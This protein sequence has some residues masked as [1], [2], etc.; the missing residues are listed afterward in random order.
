MKLENDNQYLDKKVWRCLQK[1]PKHDVKR[2]IRVNS[3]YE[4][5]NVLLFILYFLTFE[6]FSLNKKINK[7]LI[8]VK[9]L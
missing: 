2:N 3:V 1:S 9:D 5:F 6:C 7:S 8:D 4:I